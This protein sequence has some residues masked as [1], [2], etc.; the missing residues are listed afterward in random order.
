VALGL[1]SQPRAIH[2]ERLI[3]E[4][5]FGD[6]SA[7]VKTASGNWQNPL[8][9]CLPQRNVRSCLRRAF[10]PTIAVKLSTRSAKSAEQVRGFQLSV[11][12]R[13]AIL[14]WAA[15]QSR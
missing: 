1:G 10:P 3:V 8:N 9:E 11:A 13:Q 6:G 14:R 5:A 2:P 7:S 15:G 12:S 4:R